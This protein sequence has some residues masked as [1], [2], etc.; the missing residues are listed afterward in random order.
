MWG[1][2]NGL[3]NGDIYWGIVEKGWKY[4]KRRGLEGDG[5]MG[6]IEGVGEKGIGGEVVDGN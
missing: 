1:I 6:Y 4:V 2:N 5:K 3:V